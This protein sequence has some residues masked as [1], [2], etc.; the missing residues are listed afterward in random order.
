MAQPSSASPSQP[1]DVR[2]NL[3]PRTKANASRGL[4]KPA[5]TWKANIDEIRQGKEDYERRRARRLEQLEE[6]TGPDLEHVKEAVKGE[7]LLEVQA[8]LLRQLAAEENQLKGFYGQTEL[9]ATEFNKRL[10]EVE[11]ALRPVRN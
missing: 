3:H 6:R 1:V 2:P 8:I 7:S 5:K 9:S 10:K 11:E 4:H